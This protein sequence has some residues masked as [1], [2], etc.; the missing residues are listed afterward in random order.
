MGMA[1]RME[2]ISF[3]RFSVNPSAWLI[4]S[5]F[6]NWCALFLL[7][8]ERGRLWSMPKELLCVID[9]LFTTSRLEIARACRLNFLTILPK[10]VKV[11]PEDQR[12][13]IVQALCSRG[14]LPSPGSRIF[15]AE[16]FLPWFQFLREFSF[17]F[18][19]FSFSRGFFLSWVRLL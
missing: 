8:K 4:L 18:F 19:N 1:P 7:N 6:S 17:F 10:R 12:V 15:S 9:L 2:G 14:L 16:S 13:V 5:K 11:L 3:R